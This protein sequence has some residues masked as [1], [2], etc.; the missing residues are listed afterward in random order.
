MHMRA[1]QARWSLR[2]SAKN[3]SSHSN[4]AFGHVKPEASPRVFID[5]EVETGQHQSMMSKFDTCRH[6]EYSQAE[7]LINRAQS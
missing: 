1:Q 7:N 6:S 5:R 4:S 2:A 3:H